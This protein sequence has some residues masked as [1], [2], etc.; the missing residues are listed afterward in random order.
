[1]GRSAVSLLI[2][3]GLISADLCGQ[4][5][6][7]LRGTVV[8][9]T[10]AVL[11]SVSMTLTQKNSNQERRQFTDSSGSYVFASLGNGDYSLRAEFS[12]FK[13]QVRDGITLQV[14]Q[15]S[16]VDLSLEVGAI[17][18]KVTVTEDLSLM[19]TANAEISEVISNQRLADLPLNGRQF[20]Q[21]TLLSD[22]VYL[23][24]VGTRGAALAQTG[25]QV[26]IAGQRVGH[27][28]Y[29]LDGVSI[30]DQYFNNL[31]IS[32]SMEALQEFKIEKSI[33]SAEF[34]GKA[35]ANVNAVTKAG[36]NNFHGTVLEFLRNDVF[37]TRNYFDP[38]DKAK[39]PLRLNQFGGSLGGPISKNRLFFFT[40]YEGSVERR[41]LTRTFSLPSLKVRGGDFSGLP[42]IYDPLKFDSVTGRRFSFEGNKIPPER[43]S[44]V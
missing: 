43:L 19:R 35:S 41:G 3:L 21:L 18:E 27:N 15:R 44:S 25:R 30:T 31:V 39:P 11:P 17:D 20:V 4:N 34:G 2:L 14:G 38:R 1:M 42:T 10:G 24:P 37:D 13:S 8:D 36:S 32:P 23:T 12:G 29:T 26:V 6:A 40:N 33:Y 7:E 28:L 16:Q 22:N 5:T 9:Q